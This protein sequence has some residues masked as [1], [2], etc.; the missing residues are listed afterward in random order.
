[1]SRLHFYLMKYGLVGA[2]KRFFVVVW[3]RLFLNKNYVFRHDGVN[4]ES[5]HPL[6]AVTIEKYRNWL[7]VPEEYRSQIL[8]ELGED[9]KAICENEFLNH[10]LFWVILDQSNV[11]AVQWSRK[12]RYIPT[13]FIQLD[14]EDV[15]IFATTTFNSYRGNR[16]APYVMNEI[17]KSETETEGLAYVDCKVW[18]TSARK[19]IL[20]AGFVQFLKA[21]PL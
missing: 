9:Y 6:I 1:M 12:G 8:E 11:V 4:S 2:V 3:R 13:W 19:G 15:V 18:N 7:E 21:K 14:E 10:G 20:R 5:L 17:V 16:I